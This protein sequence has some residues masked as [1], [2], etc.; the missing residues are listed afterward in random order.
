MPSVIFRHHVTNDLGIGRSFRGSKVRPNL[1]K[2]LHVTYL[3]QPTAPWLQDP[4][5]P[6]IAL[7]LEVNR[8]VHEVEPDVE[9]TRFHGRLRIQPVDAGF[10][11]PI[12]CHHPIIFSGFYTSNRVFTHQKSHK[13]LGKLPQSFFRNPA[14]NSIHLETRGKKKH[15]KGESRWKATSKFGRGHHKRKATGCN[16]WTSTQTSW[17]LVCIS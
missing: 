4:R 11:P 2:S 9:D 5:A 10:G 8:K 7:V 15:I 13:T 3:S 16:S 12:G 1:L 6:Y 17:F 14:L